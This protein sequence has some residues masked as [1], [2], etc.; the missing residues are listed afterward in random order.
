M[1]PSMKD[2]KWKVLENVARQEVFLEKS[3]ETLQASTVRFQMYPAKL[4]YK[5]LKVSV[6]FAS[7]RCVLVPSTYLWEP[8]DI[9]VFCIIKC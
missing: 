9:H 2:M 6:A 5:I 1:N 4:L 8:N 7:M 3:L